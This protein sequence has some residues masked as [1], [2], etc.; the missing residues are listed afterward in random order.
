[1]NSWPK[2]HRPYENCP[3]CKGAGCDRCEG[4]HQNDY[5]SAHPTGAFAQFFALAC[6]PCILVAESA[7]DPERV[8]NMALFARAEM[9][10][11]ELMP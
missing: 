6:N 8:N 5:L 11:A 2:W 1:M 3:D 7:A 9:T 10:K 4:A